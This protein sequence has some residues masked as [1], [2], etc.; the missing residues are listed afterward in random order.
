M[1]DTNKFKRSVKEWVREN[2]N[3]T[4]EELVDFCESMIPPS[5]F[6]NYA[7]LLEQTSGWYE[8]VL[9]TRKSARLF[10]QTEIDE[11]A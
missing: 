1:F 5:Q 11:V 8:H 10:D 2:P 9:S 7:W 4:V 3:G 6:S